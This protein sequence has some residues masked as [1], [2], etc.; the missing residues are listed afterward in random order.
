VAPKVIVLSGGPN[1]VHV[2]GSPKVPAGFFDYCQ[3]NSIPVL[4]VCYGM[5]MIVQLLGG[6]V[7]TATN[8]G[9]YGRMPIDIVAGSSLFSYTS[10]S[11][12]NVWMSHGDEAVQLPEGFSVVAKSRQ[13]RRRAARAGCA[14][15]PRWL[16]RPRPAGRRRMQLHT[17]APWP[18][19]GLPA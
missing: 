18:G 13:V 16:V 1:S 7:E 6:Q 11:S 15:R 4:G 12:T 8:G 9:E 3:Q 19:R 2:E 17:P 10:S 14:G 5:Q